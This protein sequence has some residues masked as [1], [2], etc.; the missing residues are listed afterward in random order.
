MRIYVIGP[1]TGFD[2][3][4]LPAFEEARRM[5]RSAGYV[6]LI[7]HD[8]VSETAD[9]QKAMRISLETIAKAD[10]IAYLEGW[11]KSYGARLEYGIA[12]NLGIEVASVASWCAASSR[13]ASVAER[14]RRRK[15]CL[16]CR[17][18]L[19]L[20]FF[21][22][23]SDSSEEHRNHCRDCAAKLQREGR[24]VEQA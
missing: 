13:R 6:P 4:N 10:G 16:H 8:F 24:D 9:W 17:R 14:M 19:P 18:I 22:Q 11:Q 23:P 15:L 1:I 3:L 2:D 7:P 12:S 5:L 21:E 20:A